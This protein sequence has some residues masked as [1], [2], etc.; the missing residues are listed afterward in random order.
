M[1]LVTYVGDRTHDCYM[2]K[3]MYDLMQQKDESVQK[4]KSLILLYKQVKGHPFV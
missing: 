1:E 2:Q 3:D 4:W